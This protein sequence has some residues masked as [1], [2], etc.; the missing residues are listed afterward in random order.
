M[1][2]SIARVAA[3]I[4]GGGLALT[5]CAD[6]LATAPTPA[7]EAPA[8]E[9]EAAPAGSALAEAQEQ[10]YI[11]IRCT[12]SATAL[13]YFLDGVPLDA[14]D[15]QEED[16]AALSISSIEVVKGSLA[17]ELYGEKARQGAILIWTSEEK[18]QASDIGEQGAGL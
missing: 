13:V 3:V 4:L 2:N 11:H 8:A 18:R 1:A 7:D 9:A 5:G 6:P 10:K 12:P 15:Y 14:V 16:W 17:A